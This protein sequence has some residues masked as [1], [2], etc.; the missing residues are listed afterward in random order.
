MN[1]G[2][3]R[4]NGLIAMLGIV[5][6]IGAYVTTGQIIPDIFSNQSKR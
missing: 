6:G 1:S 5:A 4:L 2:A 3:E